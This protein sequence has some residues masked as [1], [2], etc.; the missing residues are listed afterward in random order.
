MA[1]RSSQLSLARPAS[2]A[3]TPRKMNGDLVLQKL[4][5][6]LLGQIKLVQILETKNKFWNPVEF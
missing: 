1:L 4:V 6:I 2:L 3:A 5:Q